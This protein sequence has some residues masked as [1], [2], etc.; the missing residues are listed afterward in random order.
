MC[1]K[2]TRRLLAALLAVLTALSIVSCSSDEPETI[3]EPDAPEIVEEAP[4]EPEIVVEEESVTT[5]E[6][7]QPEPPVEPE[8]PVEPVAEEPAAPVVVAPVIVEPEQPPAQEEPAE[9]AP[10]I[11]DYAL[12]TNTMKF[13]KMTCSSVGKIKEKN[14]GDFTGTRDEVMARG[15]DPCGNC[16]P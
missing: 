4:A 10:E 5:E 8:D 11:H 13:H 15:F 6:I 16:H 3:V 1:K 12:N 14:R 2:T 7:V 9:P